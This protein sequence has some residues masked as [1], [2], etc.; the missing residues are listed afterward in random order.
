[1]V[2][3]GMVTF[4]VYISIENDDIDDGGDFRANWPAV[5]GIMH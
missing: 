1:M 2:S 4:H 5:S 3:L